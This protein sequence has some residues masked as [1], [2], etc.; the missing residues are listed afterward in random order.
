MER[1]CRTRTPHRTHS[2]CERSKQ[3]LSS[4]NIPGIFRYVL[5]AD[6]C[7]GIIFNQAKLRR[8]QLRAVKKEK[9]DAEVPDDLIIK[10]EPVAIGFTHGEVV[11]LMSD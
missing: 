4:K 7:Y 10:E 8:V 5:L 1:K 11:D 3:V 6:S 9:R 2:K